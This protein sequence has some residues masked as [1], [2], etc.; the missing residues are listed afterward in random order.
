[1]RQRQRPVYLALGALAGLIAAASMLPGVRLWGVNH[2]AHLPVAARVIV[3]TALALSFLPGVARR[4]STL[5]TTAVSGVLGGS[6]GRILAFSIAFGVACVVLHSRTELLGDGQAQA[7]E[8][9]RSVASPDM[10]ITR[11]GAI[12][13]D[14][15]RIAVASWMLNFLAFKAAA[16]AGARDPI[17]GMHVLYA[18]FGALTAFAILLALRSSS[19]PITFRVVVALACFFSGGVQLFFGHM[20]MYTPVVSLVVVYV[21]C[22]VGASS[23]RVPLAVPGVVLLLAIACHVQALLYAPAFAGL[24]L[25]RMSRRPVV[26]TILVGA[27]T[28]LATV[29]GRFATGLG[30]FFLP[31]AAVLAPG[32][33]VDIANEMLLVVPLALV[34]IAATAANHSQRRFGTNDVIAW[35]VFVPCAMFLFLFFPELGMPRDW[36][37]YVLPA[38][39]VVLPLFV[40]LRSTADDSVP[41]PSWLVPAAMVGLAVAGPWVAV[42]ASES[43]AVRHYGNILE[44]DKTNLGYGYEILSLHH[45]GRGNVAGEIAALQN[46]ADESKNPRYYLALGILRYETGDTLQAIDDLRR[47]LEIRPSQ[48]GARRYFVQWAFTKG[49]Y[50]DDVVRHSRAGVDAY[51]EDPYYRLYLGAGYLRAGRIEDGVH[52]LEAC[53]RLDPPDSMR[54]AADQMLSRIRRP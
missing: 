27:L 17:A 31:A 29:G 21:A 40:R 2:L 51:P 41:P 28:V 30:E 54:R 43:V 4:G 16:A 53:K 25:L 49:I 39:G 5:L 35:L 6:V 23:G 52:E 1:M 37:L 46:A 10:T 9:R 19:A 48:D 11:Y 38:A 45:R 3:L 47:A 13:A 20:E 36:D 32:H 14:Q 33:L 7:N 42:N 34:F 12:M 44:F 8:I 18:L 50:N 22:L 15:E 24:V 26:I